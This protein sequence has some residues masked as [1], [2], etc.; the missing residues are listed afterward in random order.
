MLIKHTPGPW[1]LRETPNDCDFT[2]EIDGIACIY[3][4]N[5]LATANA[6]LI[7]AAPE[8]LEALQAVIAD[9]DIPECGGNIEFNI[10]QQVRAAIKKATEI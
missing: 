5:G 3:A 9:I 10:V 8:L 4:G 1:K 2:H 6:K 7:A